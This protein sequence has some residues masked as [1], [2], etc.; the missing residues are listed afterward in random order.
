MQAKEY[1]KKQPS[2]TGDTS[3]TQSLMAW[4]WEMPTEGQAWHDPFMLIPDWGIEGGL[5]NVNAFLLLRTCCHRKRE[6][7]SQGNQL[8]PSR[9]PPNS[10]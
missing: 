6:F 10:S 3:L 9:Q 2:I 4:T 5:R 8:Y 7:P 1:F